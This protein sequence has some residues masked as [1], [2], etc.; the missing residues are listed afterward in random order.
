MPSKEET[1]MAVWNA[2]PR[3]CRCELLSGQRLRAFRQRVAEAYFCRHWREALKHAHELAFCCGQSES[4]WRATVDWFLKPETVMRILEG[5]YDFKGKYKPPP[6]KEINHR[7][8][9]PSPEEL[10]VVRQLLDEA[11]TNG[12]LTRKRDMK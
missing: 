5:V 2:C 11:F 10:R 3:F 9:P 12:S 8:P 1:F 4:G 6:K 7:E